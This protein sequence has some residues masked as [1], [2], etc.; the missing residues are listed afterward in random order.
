M[1]TEQRRA[2]IRRALLTSC[3]DNLVRETVLQTQVAEEVHPAPL[4]SEIQDELRSLE[5]QRYI[6][7]I[8]PSMGGPTK[9]IATDHGRAALHD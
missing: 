5:A 4:L 8:N 9:W 2:A 7:G 3:R 1:T 6:S